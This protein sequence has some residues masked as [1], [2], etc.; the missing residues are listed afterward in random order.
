[1]VSY[2]TQGLCWVD[3]FSSPYTDS[4][5]SRIL[6]AGYLFAASGLGLGA[7]SVFWTW[8]FTGATHTYRLYIKGVY[9]SRD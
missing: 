3:M 5:D 7:L 8:G 4:C 1:M 2:W 9:A 6:R